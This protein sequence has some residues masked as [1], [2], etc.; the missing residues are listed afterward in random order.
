MQRIRLKRLSELDAD[1]IPMLPSPWRRLWVSDQLEHGAA[2]SARATLGPSEACDGGDVAGV[3]D[4]HD[5]ERRGAARVWNRVPEQ[6]RQ[7][8]AHGAM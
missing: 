1:V 3:V 7:N 2:S 5:R 6:A 4:A 8:V